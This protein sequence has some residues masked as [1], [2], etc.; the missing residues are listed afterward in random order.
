ML[1]CH[2]LWCHRFPT[3]DVVCDVACRYMSLY[4]TFLTRGTNEVNKWYITTEFLMIC[5]FFTISSI[6]DDSYDDKSANLT[7]VVSNLWGWWI[8]SF[9][10]LLVDFA[11]TLN[12]L[13][14]SEFDFPY[15]GMRMPIYMIF[16][17]L[18]SMQS[19]TDS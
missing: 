3:S 12:I 13:W 16:V 18:T 6:Y 4:T 5:G 11:D 14:N 19:L 7:N 15:L 10:M 8:Q 2:C 17:W 9:Q 1:W